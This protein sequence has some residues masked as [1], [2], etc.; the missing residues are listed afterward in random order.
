[1]LI[2][3]GERREDRNSGGVPVSVLQK[4]KLGRLYL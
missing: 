4:L 2:G 3:T 1:M